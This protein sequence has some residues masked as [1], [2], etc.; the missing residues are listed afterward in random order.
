METRKKASSVLAWNCG[1]I[2]SG[3]GVSEPPLTSVRADAVRIRGIGRHWH[4][5]WV[6]HQTHKGKWPG[7]GAGV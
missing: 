6:F 3:F 5:W 4:S 2:A 7:R 1:T